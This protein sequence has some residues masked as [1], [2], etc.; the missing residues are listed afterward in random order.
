MHILPFKKSNFPNFRKLNDNGGSKL[1]DTIS[2]FR[3]LTWQFFQSQRSVWSL[4]LG[5]GNKN[6]KGKRTYTVLAI[7]G[8]PIL[9]K[10]L[11]G[12]KALRKVRPLLL[13]MCCC[14]NKGVWWNF[15]SCKLVGPQSTLAFIFYQIVGFVLHPMGLC[16]NNG[17][18]LVKLLSVQTGWLPKSLFY[19]LSDCGVSL[20]GMLYM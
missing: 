12:P 5:D 20:S 2:C 18:C 9:I 19:V 7:Y 17:R 11:V 10:D 16:W 4:T 1:V 14:W 8:G 6:I 3:K 13:S 15:S